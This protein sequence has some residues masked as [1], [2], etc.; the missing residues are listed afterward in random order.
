MKIKKL[1]KE[2][3]GISLKGSKEVEITGVSNNSKLISPGNLFIA[4]K[5]RI[6]DGSNFIG[7]AIEAGAVAIATDIYDPTLYN[8]VQLI[9]PS[10]ASI[11]GALAANYYHFPCEELYTVGITGTNGKTTTSYYIK[12]LLDHFQ[13]PCGLIGTIECIIGN[14]RYQATRTTPDVCSNQKMLREM[15]LQGCR[16]AVMEVTSHALD[17]GRADYIDFDVAVFTNLSL[18]HLDYHQT[19]ERYAAAKQKLFSSLNPKKIKKNQSLPKVAIVNSDCLW[20][21]QMLQ[22]CKAERMTYGIVNTSDLYCTDLKCSSSGSRF[23]L[24]YHGETVECYNP[25]IGRYN[26]YNFMAATAVGLARKLPL[27]EIVDCLAKTPSISGRLENVPNN[28]GVNI[29]V[30]FAHSDD[31]LKNVF[32]SLKE[33]KNGRII[34]LFGCGGDRDKTKRPKMAEVCEHFADLTIVTNDNPRCENPEEICRDII[35]GFSKNANY[36]IELDRKEAIAKAI[37][38]AEPGDILLIAGKG[39]EPYQIFAHHTLEFDDCQVALDAIQ[40]NKVFKR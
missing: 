2:I 35:R 36:A 40:Q 6:S 18:D 37:R 34:A 19:M 28:L 25:M 7:E 26:V 10:I 4:K 21:R 14:M 33:I 20:H 27:K 5:G 13:G 39:H 3:P 23:M 17:Q 31:A 11:E 29:F 9:H 38:L 15:I 30:D 8:T 16:S 24:H 12:H 32:V 22:D 1:I